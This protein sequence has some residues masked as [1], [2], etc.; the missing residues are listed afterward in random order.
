MSNKFLGF[1]TNLYDNDGD[2]Y[3]ECVLLHIDDDTILRFETIE[4]LEKFADDIK[5]MLEEIK[6]CL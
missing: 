1:S 6:T 3:D 2:K 4:Q 5:D